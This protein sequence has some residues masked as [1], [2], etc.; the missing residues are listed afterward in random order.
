MNYLNHANTAQCNPQVMDAVALYYQESIDDSDSLCTYKKDTGAIV[1]N[2]AVDCKHKRHF[3]Q[4]N[5]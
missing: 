4:D 5:S 1:D 3:V 2:P